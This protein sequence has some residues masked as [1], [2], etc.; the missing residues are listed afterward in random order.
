ML[1][2][3]AQALP[4]TNYRTEIHLDI[5]TTDPAY[6]HSIKL[7]QGSDG[8]V[9]CCCCCCPPVEDEGASNS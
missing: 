4:E 9:G 7:G 1:T 6:P 2:Q 3:Q 5:R 8:Q